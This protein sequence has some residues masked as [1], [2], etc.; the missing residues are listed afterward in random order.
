MSYLELDRYAMLGD[1]ERQIGR[2]YRRGEERVKTRLKEQHDNLRQ[3]IVG[4]IDWNEN[5]LKKWKWYC[6]GKIKR[7]FTSLRQ[8][9]V[10][11]DFEQLEAKGLLSPG[12]YETL[13]DFFTSSEKNVKALELIDEKV[14]D[15]YLSVKGI[16]IF[17]PYW[18]AEYEI[19]KIPKILVRHPP[20][21]SLIKF[22]YSNSRRILEDGVMFGAPIPEPILPSTSMMDQ[23]LI[24]LSSSEEEWTTFNGNKCIYG[25]QDTEQNF[26]ISENGSIIKGRGW[27]KVRE[28]ENGLNLC[29]LGL[30][31]HRTGHLTEKAIDAATY[32]LQ[33]GLVNGLIAKDYDII[34]FPTPVSEKRSNHFTEKQNNK[35]QRTDNT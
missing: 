1:K 13:K 9:E 12:N 8:K 35:R 24:D 30:E 26:F 16:P 34:S 4:Y 27:E 33:F 2:C 21:Y 5:I 20:I 17:M 23:S 31:T 11:E 25:N 18:N 10:F 15:M 32:L 7:E 3:D 29:F 19:S 14:N 22:N 28:S 6:R